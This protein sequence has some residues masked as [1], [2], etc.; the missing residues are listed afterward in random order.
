MW[1]PKGAALIWGPTLIR[2]N[3][4]LLFQNCYILNCFSL[5]I[6]GSCLLIHE[7]ML[8][9]KCDVLRD[10]VSFVQFEKREK[11]PWR[12]VTFSKALLKV[13]LLHGCFSRFLNCT[14]DTKSRNASQIWMMILETTSSWFNLLHLELEI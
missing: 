7:V 5:I 10:L 14:H 1:I 2:G 9:L 12:S 6:E 4:V 3:M 11:H 8:F 13:T